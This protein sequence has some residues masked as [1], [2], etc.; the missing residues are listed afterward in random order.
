MG[1]SYRCCRVLLLL[2]PAT[3]SAVLRCCML[4]PPLLSVAAIAT[5]FA[6]YYSLLHRHRKGRVWKQG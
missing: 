1:G 6:C 4:P 3:T 2:L 5:A